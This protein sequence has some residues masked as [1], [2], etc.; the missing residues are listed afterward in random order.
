MLR[1]YFTISVWL[2]FRP[3]EYKKKVSEYVRKYASEEALRQNNDGGVSSSSES[4]MSD[5]SEDEAQ[6]IK[7]LI[8]FR[9]AS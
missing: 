8:T 6:V 7:T 5:Y 3:E 4:S 9:I 1:P 2:I